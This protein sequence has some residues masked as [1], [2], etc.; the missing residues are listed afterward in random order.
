MANIKGNDQT[1]P[2]AKLPSEGLSGNQVDIPGTNDFFKAIVDTVRQPIL[3]L[4]DDLKIE[5]ANRAFF[6]VFKASPEATLNRKIY[7][8]GNGQWNIPKLRTLLEDILVR[9]SAFEDFDVEHHFPDIGRKVMRLNARRLVQEKGNGHKTLLAIE[10]ITESEK[11]ETYRKLFETAHDGIVVLDFDNG[12][13]T[14]TNLILSKILGFSQDEMLG[15]ELWE[16][17]LF[18]NQASSQDFFSRI[19]SNGHNSNQNLQATTKDGRNIDIELACSTYSVGGD[20]LVQCN[21]RDITERVRAERALRISEEKLRQSHKMAA[22]GRL[23]GGIAHD[24][25]NLLTSINGFSELCLSV[26]E[27]DGTPHKY[28]KEILAAGERASELTKKLLAYSRQLVL[29]PK[30]LDLNALISEK[31]PLLR[32]MVREEVL[33]VLELDPHLGAI[34]VDPDQVEQVLINLVKNAREAIAPPNPG[35]II[36]STKNVELDEEYGKSHP[37]VFPGQYVRLS[38]EDTGAGMDEAVLSRIFEPFFSTKSMARSTGL[39]LSMVHGIVS[40][41]EGYIFVYSEPRIG[42]T[43][44]IYLPRVV[45]EEARAPGKA[46]NL[47]ISGSGAIETVLVVENDEAVLRYTRKILESYGYKV[48]HAIDGEAALSVANETRFAFQVLLTDIIMPGI[49]GPDLAK[50]LRAMHPSCRTLFM[51]GYGDSVVLQH[52][53]AGDVPNMIQKPFTPK[54]LV[55]AV[56]GL[57]DPSWTTAGNS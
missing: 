46:D 51:S 38:V 23:A 26:V 16:V 1:K 54:D 45:E 11:S 13:I 14:D 30:V 5:A 49:N 18:G 35:R 2:A 53:V 25:N 34:K 42:S 55:A 43:F 37:L 48:L 19:Q 7:N 41:C 28:L 32:S 47:R 56:K 21:A 33:I 50:K 39:G 12:R 44:K 17:G 15:K 8:L 20:N 3:V 52:G 6:R 40:Q 29:T 4:G 22:I 31:L 36:L 10:D 27:P 24:F 9:D 57:P